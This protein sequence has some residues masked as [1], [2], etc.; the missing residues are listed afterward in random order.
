[1]LPTACGLVFI[2]VAMRARAADA[3]VSFTKDVAPILVKHCQA[4]HAG[5]EP[6]GG[7]QV[8]SYNLVIKPGESESP[9][10]TAGRPEESELFNLVS[11]TDADQRMPRESDPLP[12]GQI[13]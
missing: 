3:P 9:S 6:K 4:C 5:P 10:V 11:S 12:A 2:L 8:A 1:M 7:Y 13:E